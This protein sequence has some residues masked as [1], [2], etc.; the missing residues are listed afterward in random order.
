MI[1]NAASGTKCWNTGGLTGA[2]YNNSENSWLQS[3][4]FDFS[5]LQHPEIAF[6]IF[7]ETEQKHD[8]AALVYSTDGVN[9]KLLGSNTYN[10]C[11]SENWYNTPSITYLPGK[12][13]G[14]SG[15]IQSTTGNCLGGNGSEKWLD[16]KHDLSFLAGEK[17]VI[18]RFLFVSGSICNDFEGIAI[19]DIQIREAVAAPADFS[20]TCGADN[21][22]NFS[23]ITPCATGHSWNFGD[24]A[25]G[26]ENINNG[27]KNPTHTFSSPG[28]Y[29]VTLT[30][31]FA[32]GTQS[33]ISK[34]IIVLG[35]S[36]SLDQSIN[37]FG[38]SSGQL[39][40]NASGGNGN[41]QYE[42]KTNPTQNTATIGGL[43]AGVYNVSV[44]APNACTASASFNLQ[45]PPSIQISSKITDARCDKN[46]G[47]VEIVVQGGIAPYDYLW[48]NGS[49]QTSIT[50]LPAGIYSVTITDKN[51]C[52]KTLN[53]LE[54]KSI[55]S[56][57]KVNLGADTTVCPELLLSPG[58]FKEYLW[59]NGSTSSD[60]LATKTGRYSIKVTDN[61]GCTAS[62]EIY[63]T[64]DC[65]DI[66]FPNAF[67]PNGDGLNDFFG[68]I[69]NINLIQ[70][71][72]LKVYDRWGQII[73]YSNQ[74][75]NKWSGKVKEIRSPAG[76]YTWIA[77]YQLKGRQPQQKKGTILL[78][79]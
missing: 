13:A 68:A 14:W 15:S 58:I 1:A 51:A 43:K 35:A 50:Q 42:W 44:S 72:E 60:F 47:A 75:Q 53:Q 12:T 48:S 57:L 16:A 62:D 52:K 67:T 59:Q 70:S 45:E 37:C 41:Y 28:E 7:W 30:A 73:F 2:H 8:G 25:S 18:F 61:D 26:A 55:P 19:D 10:P 20:Y 65:T 27:S 6:K 17:M 56:T 3:P 32:N 33:V 54:V 66:Y 31:G 69:G 34:K 63:V 71:Y 78:V 74:P 5:N 38:D 40:V 9:W 79:R 49:K 23:N 77:Q 22:L 46:N 36:I 24:P 11:Q 76:I 39:T 21:R 64:V 4:C 29:T